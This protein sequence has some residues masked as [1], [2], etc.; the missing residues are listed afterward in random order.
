MLKTRIISPDLSAFN[1]IFKA[2]NMLGSMF[3][4]QTICY[5]I[6]RTYNEDDNE[7]NI[8]SI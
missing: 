4:Q 7:T 1:D 3:E 5:W 6:P 2:N 8:E